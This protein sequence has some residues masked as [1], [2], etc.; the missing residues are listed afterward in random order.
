MKNMIFLDCYGSSSK[1]KEKQLFCLL[2]SKVKRNREFALSVFDEH[3]SEEIKNINDLTIWLS[4]AIEN[5]KL[6]EIRKL[7]EHT[8][9]KVV[10]RETKKTDLLVVSTKT[11]VEE[12]PENI[13]VISG[14]TFKKI[15]EEIEQK[16][17]NNHLQDDLDDEL[18]ELLLHE[19]L[20]KVEEGLKRLEQKSISLKTL[21]LLVALFKVHKKKHIRTESK[22]LLEKESAK[23]V[24]DVLSF[25][26]GRNF[27]N[28]K[29]TVGMDELA[30]IKGFSIDLFLYYLV[31]EQKN[32]L[33][34]EYLA[35][36]D[37]DWTQKLL[38]ENELLNKESLELYGKAGKRFLYAKNILYFKVHANSPVLWK[39]DWLK[40]LEIID[41]KE[42]IILPK[43]TNFSCLE[44]LVLET[45]ELSLVGILP[46]KKL[47]FRKC[48]VLK[49][50]D[51]FN[52]PNIET[53][54]L[55]SCSFNLK[56]FKDFLE[57]EKFLTLKKIIIKDFTSYRMPKDF[58]EQVKE[59]LPKI[60]LSLSIS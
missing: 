24:K 6:L 46:I 35:S 41:L 60:E 31:L 36:L 47:V 4:G 51:E 54:T 56:I 9:T 50:S 1:P 45:K 23:T 44:T 7:L 55:E 13:K 29:Y 34:K 25:C 2:R 19:K 11:K 22:A 10:T 59:I 33:G 48:K 18:I 58:E 17:E 5:Y 42:K 32:N 40:S 30:K 20:E 8:N 38:E 37:S 15:L 27:L 12:V 14:I 57:K 52:M 21:P 43:S 3:Y 28:A 53:I 16:I 39:M 26:E 49:I